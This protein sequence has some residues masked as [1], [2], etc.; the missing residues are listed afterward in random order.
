M[1]LLC[2]EGARLE[3]L[4]VIRTKLLSSLAGLDRGYVFEIPA[5]KRLAIV[6]YHHPLFRSQ[7]K[8]WM[9]KTPEASKRKKIVKRS[10]IRRVP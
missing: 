1:R 9:R 10:L 7:A 5:L 8:I 6:G 2:F 4:A 3:R